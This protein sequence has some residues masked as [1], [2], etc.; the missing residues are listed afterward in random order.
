MDKKTMRD[1][2][3]SRI[4]FRLLMMSQGEANY[5]DVDVAVMNEHLLILRELELLSGAEYIQ[6]RM[7]IQDANSRKLEV[8]DIVQ[9]FNYISVSFFSFV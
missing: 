6:L 8:A 2:L 1:I 4:D 7:L 5:D 3:L 9:D